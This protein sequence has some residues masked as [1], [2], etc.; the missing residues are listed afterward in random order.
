MYEYK[1]QVGIG[2]VGPD[3]HL[4]P[5]SA[6]D[7]LQNGSF[8]EMN[9]NPWLMEFFEREG[10][11][12]FIVSRQ[13]EI[14]RMPSYGEHLTVRVW[15]Y[16]VEK[17]WGHRNTML[18]DE[19]GNVCIA[20]STMG[21][22][23]DVTRGRPT[24]LPQEVLDRYPT[25]PPYPMEVLPRKIKLPDVTP[26]QLEPVRVLGH[27][28]DCYGHVNNAR[29]VDLAADC[30]PIDTAFRRLRVEY[31]RA[32]KLHELITPTIYKAE[33]LTTVSLDVDGAPAAVVEFTF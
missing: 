10:L 31:K 19:A 9:T 2:H 3:N 7:F 4:K 14:L 16:S 33:G 11:G 25:E 18:Y 28:I 23:V 15:V 12:C 30:L 8:F 1:I 24:K 29:Y 17:F 32:A 5:G 22:F 26:V 21:S 6:V 27:H 20:S 13:L